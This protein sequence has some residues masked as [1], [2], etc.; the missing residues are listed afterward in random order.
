MF[1]IK[2]LRQELVD[3]KNQG[4]ALLAR[5]QAEGRDLTP[6]ESSRHNRILQSAK[7]V[8][9]EIVK[10]EAEMERERASA[11]R[12]F[13]ASGR[14]A[15]VSVVDQYGASSF[16]DHQDFFSAVMRSAT[17]GGIDPRLQ[18]APGAYNAMQGSDE[19]GLYSDPHGGYLVPTTIM[20]DIISIGAESDVLAKLVTPVRMMTTTV[21]FNARVDKNHSTSVSGGLTVARRPET[22]DGTSSRM[23]FEQVILNA[24]EL[25]GLTYASEA[26]LQDSPQSFFDLLSAGFNDEFAAQLMN[27]RING[28]GGG[29]FLGILNALASNSTGPTL[30]ISKETGQAAATIVKE[31]IDK[32]AARCWRYSKAVWLANPSTRPQLRS[33]V[34]VVGTGGN[35]V[36]YFT[37][38]AN[39]G[40]ELLDGR[41]IF[42]TEFA[43][44][45][46]TAGDLILGDWSQYLEGTIG[47][48]QRAES[49][50]VRFLANERAFKFWVR[51][52]G[53]PHWLSPL[54]PKNGDT[55]SP[56]VILQA[57]S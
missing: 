5:A 23:Q 31:N 19:Q 27:E 51:N 49:I 13:E 43:K 10:V 53:A 45:L 2:E 40:P 30:S 36:P 12:A 41:P 44:A 33:L 24:H 18:R 42:F 21:K 46:G 9:A 50:H 52:D 22:V 15:G 57:R 25:F 48:I 11:G 28:T 8:N 1:K 38:S 34:Q 17:G 32:M 37:P 4:A 47:G 16:T 26:I 29:E 20:P 6:T 3:L 7:E 55:L 35:A 39:G 14:K 56:F 54:T